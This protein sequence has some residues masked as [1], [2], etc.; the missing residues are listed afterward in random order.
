[1]DKNGSETEE[2]GNR[3]LS[4]LETHSMWENQPPILL[5]ILCYACRQELIIIVSW[6]ASSSSRWK[7]MQKP[8]AKHQ[9]ELGES[10]GRVGDG[11]EKAAGV[12]DTTED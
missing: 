1:M 2:K 3:L 4:Q 6:E 5:M 10:C 7:Q 8:I 9:A 12:K 11:I